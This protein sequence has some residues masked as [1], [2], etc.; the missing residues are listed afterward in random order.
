[1]PSGKISA[2]IVVNRQIDFQKIQK[3]TWRYSCGVLFGFSE[4]VK[5][6]I[7]NYLNLIIIVTLRLTQRCE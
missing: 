7:T 3:D 6:E 5:T 4:N 1:M 2:F